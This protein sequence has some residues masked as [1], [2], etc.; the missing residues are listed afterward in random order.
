MH[1]AADQVSVTS[2][3][4]NARR[5]KDHGSGNLIF[6]F[7]A[8]YR[9][10]VISLQIAVR[11]TN[12]VIRLVIFFSG[13]KHWRGNKQICTRGHWRGN[14]RI[15][16]RVSLERQECESLFLIIIS[17][18]KRVCADVSFFRYRIDQ[19]T[20]KFVK[21]TRFWD[22][23]QRP[24]D[25]LDLFFFN[26]ILFSIVTSCLK[27][28]NCSIYR[29]RTCKQNHFFIFQQTKRGDSPRGN[30]VSIASSGLITWMNFESFSETYRSFS[31]APGLEHHAPTRIYR[32][33]LG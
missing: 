22:R 2:K 13:K 25:F 17:Q 15:C 7:H 11:Q 32:A 33:L 12:H 31:Q 16:T 26:I 4:V 28:T 29:L 6:Q 23:K 14:R 21:F 20:G 3:G 19:I 24:N 18:N 5:K 27:A 1:G 9:G 8:N 10:I 30:S